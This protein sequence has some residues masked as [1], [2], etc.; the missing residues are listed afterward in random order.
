M[1]GWLIFRVGFL[2]F[3]VERRREEWRGGV[4]VEG[5]KDEKWRCGGVEG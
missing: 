4:G 5:W 2:S 1:E 3:G